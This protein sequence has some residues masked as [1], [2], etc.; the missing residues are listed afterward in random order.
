MLCIFLLC[1]AGLVVGAL[2]GDPKSVQGVLRIG[3]IFGVGFVFF[4]IAAT[5]RGARTL[6][7]R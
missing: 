6:L 5:I 2:L 7:T 1:C 4:V 3:I